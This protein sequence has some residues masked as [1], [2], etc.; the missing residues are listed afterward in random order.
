MSHWR[1]DLHPRADDGRFSDV[2]AH[3]SVRSVRRASQ[4]APIGRLVQLPGPPRSLGLAGHGAEPPQAR[5][6][7]SL[8]VDFGAGEITATPTDESTHGTG[9]F[10][11]QVFD[12]PVGRLVVKGDDPISQPHREV[13]AMQ[14]A[15]W[16]G[17]PTAEAA[18]SSDGKHS[19][20]KMFPD[21]VGDLL[22]SPARPRL[23]DRIGA[24]QLPYLAAEHVLDHMLANPD[25]HGGNYVVLS[26]GTVRGVD[27]GVSMSSG[28]QHRPNFEMARYDAKRPPGGGQDMDRRLI[29]HPG[30][31]DVYEQMYA[32]VV[33]DELHPDTVAAMRSAALDAAR[34][35]QNSDEKEYLRRARE[36]R[37]DRYGETAPDPN[38]F[39]DG[40]EEDDEDDD[41]VD[42]LET[43]RNLVARVAK[44][45]DDAATQAAERREMLAIG[46][47]WPAL[48]NYDH[49]RLKTFGPEMTRRKAH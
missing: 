8:T 1:E 6:R 4:T 16:W 46:K 21:V 40:D 13:A 39:D 19:M 23:L 33:R 28:Y 49:T 14:L 26:D 5:E 32:A 44:L 48:T 38:W 30:A 10:G 24:D 12:S 47:T 31:T 42:D 2:A 7:R 15:R 34:R 43:K 45:W 20:Q 18:L 27:K 25:T 17:F 9:A 35:I 36:A 41:L 37:Q 29:P 3:A 11:A 22:Q